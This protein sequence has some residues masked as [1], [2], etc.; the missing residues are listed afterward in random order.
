VVYVVARGIT[1][2]SVHLGRL[3]EAASGSTNS[4]A[5]RR[6]KELGWARDQKEPFSSED[7]LTLLM[8]LWSK[9][10]PCER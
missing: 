8:A 3:G 6:S 1:P 7:F 10:A 9:R 4:V 2:Q 5:G